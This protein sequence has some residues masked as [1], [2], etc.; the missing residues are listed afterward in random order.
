MCYAEPQAAFHIPRFSG[1]GSAE[2][3]AS[4]NW[5]VHVVADGLPIIGQNPASSGPT[6]KV[7]I[8]VLET[9]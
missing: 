9:K 7:L 2:P 1:I 5:G 6:A 3:A 8:D 4:R